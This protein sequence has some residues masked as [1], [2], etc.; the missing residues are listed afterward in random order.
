MVHRSAFSHANSASCRALSLCSRTE[1]TILWECA[2]SLDALEFREKS[3]FLESL[4]SLQA[5]SMVAFELG[6]FLSQQWRSR[7]RPRLQVPEELPACRMRA[8]IALRL[9]LRSG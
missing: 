5:P 9:A 1:S 7:H 4:D 8:T 6:P 2:D 3:E